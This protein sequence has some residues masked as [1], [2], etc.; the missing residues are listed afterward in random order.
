MLKR[1]P[2]YWGRPSQGEQQNDGVFGCR[3]VVSDQ[4]AS[5]SSLLPA[6]LHDHTESAD[7]P[8]IKYGM[9]PIRL[10]DALL[11]TS[12]V[13]HLVFLVL[14]WTVARPRV[15]CDSARRGGCSIKCALQ[16]VLK[17]KTPRTRPLTFSHAL[18]PM[19]RTEARLSSPDAS[20]KLLY[21]TLHKLV[22]VV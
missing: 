4:T 15:V 2:V 9:H 18:D 6:S 13:A 17:L 5:Q 21:R 20:L 8:C 12:Y 19:F 1:C 22:C 11:Q 16:A 10:C 7:I 3:A 14:R